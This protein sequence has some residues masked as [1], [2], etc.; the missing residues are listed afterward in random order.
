MRNEKFLGHNDRRK[1]YIKYVWG[2]VEKS[3]LEKLN[4]GDKAA[5]QEALDQIHTRSLEENPFRGIRTFS[6]V[7]SDR[8]KGHVTGNNEG[9]LP[10]EE[11]E[12]Q[13]V[14]YRKKKANKPKV[15]NQERVTIFLYNIPENTTGSKIWSLFKSCGRIIDIILPK[16]RDV[17]GKRYGFVHTESKLEAGAIINN[18]KMDRS[19][20]GKINMTINGSS[21]KHEKGN[22]KDKKASYV[23]QEN[24]PKKDNRVEDDFSKRMFEFTELE[25]DEEVEKALLEC[26]IGFSWFEESAAVMQEKMNDI[27]L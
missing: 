8:K 21:G 16:R 10:H 19:L 22:L 13:Q 20:G 27:G 1:C 23:S 9:Q 6:E 24:G 4:I 26:K 14:S 18:A 2:W 11:E 7:L 17:R 25:I 12:W 3:V 5:V 15:V